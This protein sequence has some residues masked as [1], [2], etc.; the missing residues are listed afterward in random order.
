MKRVTPGFMFCFELPSGKTQRGR[1]VQKRKTALFPPLLGCST[2]CDSLRRCSVATPNR[3]SVEKLVR[4]ENIF[5]RVCPRAC[6]VVKCIL[7]CVFLR[8]VAPLIPK[9]IEIQWRSA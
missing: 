4:S 9:G 3:A 8:R 7:P 2:M 5:Y 6:V 1:M